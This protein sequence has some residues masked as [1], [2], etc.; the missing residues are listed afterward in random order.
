MNGKAIE[1]RLSTVENKIAEI[2]KK[3]YELES[4]INSLK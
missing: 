1:K 4:Q 3:I 2:I